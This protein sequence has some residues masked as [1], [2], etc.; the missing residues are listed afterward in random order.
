MV[1]FSLKAPGG[2]SSQFKYIVQNAPAARHF[3]PDGVD[4]LPDTFVACDH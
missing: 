2:D 3:Q 4:N 1:I